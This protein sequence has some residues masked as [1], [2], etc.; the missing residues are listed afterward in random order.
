MKRLRFLIFLIALA[1]C[2]VHAAGA[3]LVL[4]ERGRAAMRSDPEASRRLAEQALRSL[5]AQPDPDLQI[6]AHL[7]LCDYFSERDRAAAQRQIDRAQALMSRSTRP[8]LRAGVL[9]CAGEMSEFAGDNVQAMALYQQAVTVAASSNELELLA[10]A[11]F[12][13]GYLRGLQG[14]FANGLA[15]LRQ[16]I[17]IYERLGLPQQ[18]QT[19]VNGVAILYNRMG[20]YRQARNYFEASLKSQKA[21]GLTREQIVTHHNLGRVL[22]NLKEW[23]AAQ[24]AFET[25][26]A[27]SREIGYRRGEAYALRG[28]A[29]VRNARGA[30]A[31]AMNLL[32]RA[33]QLQRSTPD[34]RLRAQ[35]LLQRGIALRELQ[36][37][38]ESVYALQQ[39]LQV[40]VKAD[41]MAELGATHDELARSLT[42]LGDWKGA[43][44]HQVKFQS[45]RDT[46][47]QKQLDQRFATL[48]VEFDTAAKDKE[49]A[50]LQREKDASVRAL[51]QEKRANRLQA[52]VLALV[53]LLAVV[54][55]MLAW[56]Q[57]RTSQA[58]HTLAMTDEL[59][60][61]PNRR[62]VLARLETLLATPGRGCAL[63]IVDIDHFKSINDEHGHLVGDEILRAVADALHD[64]ARDPVALGRLGGEEFVVIEPDADEVSGRLLAERLLARVRAL[65]LN[66]LPPGRRLTVSIGLTVC[67]S[68]DTVT[69]MLRRADEALYVAKAGGRD[70]VVTRVAPPDDIDFD[71]AH[72]TGTA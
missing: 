26:L 50:L 14:E 32:D 45:T 28:L 55:A 59:T 29:S 39:A 2:A 43:Y 62:D 49:Y 19:S 61:L 34:E 63:L 64:V 27:L 20:D 5:A 13:R 41:S 11:L 40:F 68:G 24:R 23:D 12:Q 71:A 60:G 3:P 25:V 65:D 16:A 22:E 57:R 6:R 56:R 7:L 31:D 51:A 9:S 42:V 17:G 4:I 69:Q 10:D 54:L 52:A 66:R 1:A 30:A 36:R 37:P 38:S 44:E 58:M 48:R 46:L 8:G 67:G 70:R 15:D 72:V 33:S 35:I 18:A 21:A 47:L 53:V